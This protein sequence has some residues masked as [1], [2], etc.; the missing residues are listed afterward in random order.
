MA[1]RKSKPGNRSA[2][3]RRA[4]TTGVSPVQARRAPAIARMARPKPAV[5]GNTP[6]GPEVKEYRHAAKRKNNPPAGLA[7]QGVVQEAPR[8]PY[9]YNPHLPPVLR[10]DATG[11]ADKLPELLATARKRALTADE[12]RTLAEALKRHEP[13]L[14]W[15][16]KREKKGFEV[17]PVAL[18]IH[19]RISAQAILKVAARQDVQRNLFAD[20]E[21]EYQRGRAVLPARRGLVQPADPGRFACRSWPAWRGARTWRARSR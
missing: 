13:W 16:G 9:A 15:A 7:A 8:I 19:E 10:F 2:R 12:A 20:P 1:Q 5:N 4:C 18:H 14:E 6:A 11:A 3:T 21:Q 17:E